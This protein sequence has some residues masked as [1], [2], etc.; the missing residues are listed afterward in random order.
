MQQDI[1]AARGSGQSLEQEAG[2]RMGSAFGTDLSSVKV[3][4]D[5]KADKLNRSLNAK[6]FT[7]GSDIFFSRGAYQPGS[8]GGSR[9]LAHELTHVVQQGFHANNKIQPKLRLGA[10][11][12]HYE[13]EAERNAQ[14]F[15]GSAPTFSAGGKHGVQRQWSGRTS[16]SA[17]TVIRRVVKMYDTM[18]DARKASKHQPITGTETKLANVSVE[19]PKVEV[20]LNG[21]MTY[22]KTERAA[23]K[24]KLKEWMDKDARMDPSKAWLKSAFTG[25]KSLNT[26][27]VQDKKFASYEQLGQAL[28]GHIRSKQHKSTESSLAAKTKKSTY[29]KGKLREVQRAIHTAV[30]AVTETTFKQKFWTGMSGGNKADKRKGE[31]QHWYKNVKNVKSM[32]EHGTGDFK[33][34]I[35]TI[36]DAGTVMFHHMGVGK[37]DKQ[38]SLDAGVIDTWATDDDFKGT[39]EKDSDTGKVQSRERIGGAYRANSTAVNED[40]DWVKTARAH[41]ALLWAG[42]SHTTANMMKMMNGLRTKVTTLTAKHSEAVAWAIFAFWNKDF[43]TFKDGYHTFHEVMD[44]ASQSGVPYTPFVYPTDPPSA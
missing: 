32:L 14:Q 34:A 39:V 3:H 10:V 15:S 28:L 16:A 22:T 6:A 27:R 19:F 29:I 13:H 5:A 42:P 24:S 18:D 4:T 35:A 44:I 40:Y 1:Q 12:D 33:Q 23:M 31:Y 38:K 7:V 11:G 26:G 2:A 8:A 20:A 25:G 41:G 21:K 43:Y 36:H 30:E 17:Q 9:L 37:H